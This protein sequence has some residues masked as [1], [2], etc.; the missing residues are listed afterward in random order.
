M[1]VS[2]L[3]NVR[4]AYV[5]SLIVAGVVSVACITMIKGLEVLTFIA[6]VLSLADVSVP[7]SNHTR[8]S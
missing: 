1:V 2:V 7:I 6:N 8:A 4:V 3:H 5:V